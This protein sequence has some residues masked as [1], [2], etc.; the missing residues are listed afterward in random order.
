MT[1]K[2]TGVFHKKFR[3]P[4]LIIQYNLIKYL[5]DRKFKAGTFKKWDNLVK[6]MMPSQYTRIT[7]YHLET[8]Y[9]M[10]HSKYRWRKV[11][12]IVM[13]DRTELGNPFY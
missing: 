12:A 4:Y 3:N 1:S 8:K 10:C 2:V 13:Y 9:R 6:I 5:T 11:P 7:L